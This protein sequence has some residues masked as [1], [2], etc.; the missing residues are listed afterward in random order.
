MVV[1]ICMCAISHAESD[2][3]EHLFFGQRVPKGRR[4][5]YSPHTC[6]RLRYAELLS[7]ST[8]QSLYLRV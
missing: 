2:A 6:Q 1:D 5:Y 8:A 7:P 3:Q 4:T